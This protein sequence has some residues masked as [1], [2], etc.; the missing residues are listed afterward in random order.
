MNKIIQTNGGASPRLFLFDVCLY[1]F[2]FLCPVFFF[3]P[4]DLNMIQKIFFV[5][6][7]LFLLG[8]SFLCERR[9]EF[10][11]PWIG[12]IILW[13]LLGVFFHAFSFSLSRTYVEGFINF[14][15]MSEGFIYVLCGCLLY[16]L[17]FSYSQRINIVY[18][19][20][21]I[22][23]LNLFFALAQTF[24]IY[25]I[26]ENVVQP[27]QNNI[28]GLM[29]TKSQ[30]AVFS[31]MTVP[32]IF[33]LHKF[34]AF[35]PLMNLFLSGSYTAVIALFA[36]LA[37]F[38]FLRRKKKALVCLLAAGLIVMPFIG[39][40]K[41]YVRPPAWKYTLNEIVRHPIFG[42]G[43]DNTINQNKIFLTGDF[44]T[45][46]TYRHNDYLNAARDL[47]LPFLFF[48][49]MAIAKVIFRTR[50][51]PLWLSL[52][53]LMIACFA[54]TSFYYPRIAAVGIIIAALKSRELCVTV[55]Q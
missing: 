11:N 40:H 19:L 43:F 13:S 3:L 9:R 44:Q 25:P 52:I 14:C 33:S 39:W 36:G 7:V 54:Q 2:T 16:Y 17:V 35:I 10:K 23:V 45:Q 26:W 5:F 47:G 42:H 24:G 22:S 12:F 28:A 29:G 48:M 18:P 34:L 38:F 20:L 30:L 15:L 53:I 37:A 27:T 55:Q 49:F 46:Y 6:G 51:D 32:P 50:I 4:W 8:I 1:V 31:A 41:F 21:V